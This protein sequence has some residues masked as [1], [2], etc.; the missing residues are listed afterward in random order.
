MDKVEEDKISL[1][2]TH[3]Q[4]YTNDTNKHINLMLSQLKLD[5]NKSS[6]IEVKTKKIHPINKHNTL[7][8]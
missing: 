4:T 3:K 5:Y 8:N 6:K 7:T 1:T 2:H